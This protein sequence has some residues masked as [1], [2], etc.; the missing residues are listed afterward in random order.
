MILWPPIYFEILLIAT[1]WIL[2]V[3]AFKFLN[4]KNIK[5]I[6]LSLMIFLLL[7]FLALKIRSIKFGFISHENVSIFIGPD[8]ANLIKDEIQKNKKVQILSEK[9]NFYKISY[10]DNLGWVDKSDVSF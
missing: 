6:L 7:F 3:I 8:K 4:K 5:A 9:N 2:F 10:D 1:A